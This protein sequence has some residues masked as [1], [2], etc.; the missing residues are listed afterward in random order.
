[1]TQW[2][3]DRLTWPEMNTAIARKPQPV[4]ALV[5]GAVGV[6]ERAQFFKRMRNLTRQVAEAW[7]AQ[8]AEL[9]HP[10]LADAAEPAAGP[11]LQLPLAKAPS[12]S[13]AG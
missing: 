4:V 1:M 5:I 8:R 10:L 7:R 13:A 12:T 11:A 9:G 3:Y 6:T 2:R